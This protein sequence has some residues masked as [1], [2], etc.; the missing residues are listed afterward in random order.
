MTLRNPQGSLSKTARMTKA[1]WNMRT[2]IYK[3]IQLDSRL[4][5]QVLD[6][7][8]CTDIREVTRATQP[9]IRAGLV[10]LIHRFSNGVVWRRIGFWESSG[11]SMFLTS[12]IYYTSYSW[13]GLWAWA[14]GGRYGDKFN[15]VSKHLGI[16]NAACFSNT[17]HR[18]SLLE[19]VWR[20]L[21]L[22]DLEVIFLT[23][24]NMRR[25]REKNW[26]R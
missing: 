7:L 13:N 16:V 11:L 10:E 22:S 26:C 9:Y 4:S 20:V 25:S 5:R 8:V 15:P 17:E 21:S 12:H 14:A 1:V 24:T 3:T 19:D 6:V 18:I 23:L 2:H